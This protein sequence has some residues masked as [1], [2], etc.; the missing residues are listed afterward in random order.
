MWHFNQIIIIK[1]F[2]SLNNILQS[3]LLLFQ[4]SIQFTEH[5]KLSFMYLSLSYYL[6][7]LTL[8]H[9]LI[10]KEQQIQDINSVNK[11][12]E[13]NTSWNVS[14]KNNCINGIGLRKIL[15]V[16]LERAWIYNANGKEYVFWFHAF[17]LTMKLKC[18]I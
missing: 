8:Y 17:G 11:Q 5:F 3:I 4:L 2:K 15:Y 6:C 1:I 7:F 16:R 13:F 10:S 18:R 14:T 9:F 12:V